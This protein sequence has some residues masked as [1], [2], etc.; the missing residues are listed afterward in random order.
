MADLTLPPSLWWSAQLAHDRRHDDDFGPGVIVESAPGLYFAALDEGW[1]V[2]ADLPSDARRLV[3]D[4]EFE[5]ALAEPT[6]VLRAALARDVHPKPLPSVVR[7]CA[8][9]VVDAWAD[10]SGDADEVEHLAEAIEVLRLELA[11]DV[12]AGRDLTAQDVAAAFE[13]PNGFTFLTWREGVAEYLTR[14]ARGDQR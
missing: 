1:S 9:A 2:L 8:N 7:G 6:D 5:T 14:I 12:P 11:R 13:N 10:W 3:V 4:I